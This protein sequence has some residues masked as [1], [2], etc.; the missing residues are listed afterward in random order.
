MSAAEPGSLQAYLADRGDDP[1]LALFGRALAAMRADPGYLVLEADPV[2]GSL[3]AAEAPA[4]LSATALDQ[5]LAR[6]EAAEAAD[7]RAAP[8]PA[9]GGPVPGEIARL[10][11]PVRDAALA[12]LE[13]DRWRMARPGLV[14]LPLD[15]GATHCELMRIEPGVGAAEHDHDGD[16]LTLIL[17][18]AYSD[19]HAHYAAG[20]VSLARPGFVHT[21]VADPGEVCYVLAVTYGPARFKGLIGALQ[22]L[23]GY[24]WEPRPRRRDRRPPVAR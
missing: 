14:R 6:I 22:A 10:P 20:D 7:R 4:A 11:G 8:R 17:T 9:G 19:G 12:A 18:G 16:E 24:P 3:L 23:T 13:H 2:G 5:V 21:P 15:F 1:A